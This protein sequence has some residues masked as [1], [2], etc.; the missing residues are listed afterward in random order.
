MLDLERLGNQEFKQVN[1]SSTNVL[2]YCKTGAVGFIAIV[3]SPSL[4]A[5]ILSAMPNNLPLPYLVIIICLPSLFQA[6]HNQR[7]EFLKMQV[8]FL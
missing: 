6:S 1:R 2:N 8:T 7:K 3:T 4:P 5:L